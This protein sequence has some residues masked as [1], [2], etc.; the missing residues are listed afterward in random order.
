MRH[1]ALLS[2]LLACALAGCKS[3]L[4]VEPYAFFPP[5]LGAATDGNVTVLLAQGEGVAGVRLFPASETSVHLLGPVKPSAGKVVVIRRNP[6]E[7]LVLD[8]GAPLP[9][10]TAHLFTAAEASA[11]GLTFA[12]APP[13]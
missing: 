3:P 9:A 12:G 2:L 1:F 7:H 6:R 13:P 11:F 8:P 5:S 4:P 10:W